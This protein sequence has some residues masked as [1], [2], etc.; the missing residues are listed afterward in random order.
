MMTKEFETIEIGVAEG[1]DLGSII[2]DSLL[3]N[4]VLGGGGGGW[5]LF[6]HSMV[7]KW[8]T[9]IVDSIWIICQ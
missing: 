6:Y 7:C 9:S 8:T 1:I 2:K 3:P 4:V 5:K